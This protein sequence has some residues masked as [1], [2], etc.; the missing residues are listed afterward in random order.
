[1]GEGLG[2]CNVGGCQGRS[3][4]YW[5]LIGNGVGLC[6]SH[7]SSPPDG[8]YGDL[9]RASQEPPDD[10]DI[11]FDG[12]EFEEPKHIWVTKDGD[13]I[14]VSELKDQH[15]LNIRYFL[16]SRLENMKDDGAEGSDVT[17]TE[18]WISIIEEEI[19]GRELEYK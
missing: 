7:H 11:P 19:D 17:H 12:E 14:P 5:P 1:M 2:K 9:V 13:R 15:L 3:S 8:Y 4:V 6:S 16:M 10:F 18:Y